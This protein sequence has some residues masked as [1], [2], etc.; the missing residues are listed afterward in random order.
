MTLFDMVELFDRIKKNMVKEIISYLSVMKGNN[1]NNTYA[2]TIT[3]NDCILKTEII[4]KN[5]LSIY[6]HIPLINLLNN[7]INSFHT[8]EIF[9]L[10]NSDNSLI[11]FEFIFDDN[12]MFIEY[13]N[14]ITNMWCSIL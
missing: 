5:K 6:M 13:G 2:S 9:I 12:S 3:S 1:D 14:N 10:L 8:G 4:E 11:S 7:K